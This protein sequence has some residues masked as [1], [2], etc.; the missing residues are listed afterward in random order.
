MGAFVGGLYAAGELGAGRVVASEMQAPLYTAEQLN[1]PFTPLDQLSRFLIRVHTQT[2]IDMLTNDDVY[3]GRVVYFR[4]IAGRAIA[5]PCN[6]PAYLGRSLEYGNAWLA[7][8]DVTF[9]DTIWGGSLFFG[10]DTLVG[11]VYLAGGLAEEGNTS[12]Y[13]FIGSTF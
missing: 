7:R 12:L 11:P 9:G 3:L 6:V 10:M 1:T 2:S 13:L 5:T 8:E 4:R